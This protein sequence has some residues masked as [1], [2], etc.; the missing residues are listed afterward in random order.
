[1][2]DLKAKKSADNYT[3][4]VKMIIAWH[5]VGIATL[6]STSYFEKVRNSSENAKRNAIISAA[7]KKFQGFLQVRGHV[8]EPFE[9][10]AGPE[11]VRFQPFNHVPRSVVTPDTKGQQKLKPVATSRPPRKA[12]PAPA[13]AAPTDAT[14]AEGVPMQQEGAAENEQ[15]GQALWTKKRGG[16]GKAAAGT[17]GITKKAKGR[18]RGGRGRQSHCSVASLFRNAQPAAP[19][20]FV[21]D[22]SS[23]EFKQTFARATAAAAAKVKAEAPAPVAPVQ[24]PAPVVTQA[25]PAPTPR[26]PAAQPRV[27]ATPARVPA[28]PAMPAALQRAP[29]PP[30][31][32]PQPSM[33]AA[34]KKPEVVAVPEPVAAGGQAAGQATMKK[35]GLNFS[36]GAKPTV[37]EGPVDVDTDD[38]IIFE[39]ET[40]APDPNFLKRLAPNPP[41]LTSSP[42]ERPTQAAPMD[43]TPNKPPHTEMDRTPEKHPSPSS[44]EKTLDHLPAAQRQEVERMRQAV[45]AA[46]RARDYVEARMRMHMLE[47]RCAEFGCTVPQRAVKERGSKTAAPG[48]E[49]AERPEILDDL[50]EMDPTDRLAFTR[51]ILREKFPL[52]YPSDDFIEDDSDLYPAQERSSNRGGKRP[53]R[54]NNDRTLEEQHEGDSDIEVVGEEM[55]KAKA[56][57]AA[58]AKIEDAPYED[59]NRFPRVAETFRHFLTAGGLDPGNAE[60]EV[61][62]LHELFAQ[63]EK[64]LHAMASKEYAEV[65]SSDPLHAMVIEHF[66][67]FWS[68]N[69]QANLVPA[70]ARAERGIEV[71]TRGAH[72]IPLN[73]GVRVVQ[74]AH[75]EDLVILTAPDGVTQ[76]APASQ[77]HT[78]EIMRSPDFQNER[79]RRKAMS[80][81]EQAEEIRQVTGRSVAT[82]N[83]MEDSAPDK[84]GVKAEKARVEL[85]EGLKAMM[86]GGATTESRRKV[87]GVLFRQQVACASCGRAGRDASGAEVDD[88]LVNED[89]EM[90]NAA[91]ERTRWTSYED[92]PDATEEEKA[93][94]PAVLATFYQ[95][96]YPYLTGV[97]KLMELYKKRP[98]DMATAEFQRL[99]RHD[100]ENAQCNGFLNSAILYLRKFRETGG[101]EDLVD[102]S[103]LD[104]NKLQNLF[105]PDFSRNWNKEQDSFEDLQ[106]EVPLELLMA[107][108][109][110]EWQRE[111]QEKLDEEN[112]IQEDVDA[113]GHRPQQLSIALLPNATPEEWALWPRI[114]ARY[115]AD[116]KKACD[117]VKGMKRETP[118]GMKRE[119]YAAEL[120]NAL[121]ELIEEH[122][123]SPQAMASKKYVKI[124]RTAYLRQSERERAVTKFADFWAV[125]KDEEFP[126]PKIHS[127]ATHKYKLPELHLVEQAKR[128]ASE[129]MLPEGWAIRL[130]KDGRVIR[131]TGTQ[132]QEVYTTKEAAM[133]AAEAKAK[134]LAEEAKAQQKQILARQDAR[135]MNTNTQ[136]SLVAR[137][138][139]A[140]EREDYAAASSLQAEIGAGTGK[141]VRLVCGQA[142]EVETNDADDLARP[143]RAG[144]MPVVARDV[145]NSGGHGSGK[146]GRKG[147]KPGKKALFHAAG[148]KRKGEFSKNP[149]PNEATPLK[150]RKAQSLNKV[151]QQQAVACE[152]TL[153]ANEWRILGVKSEGLPLLPLGSEELQGLRPDQACVVLAKVDEEV[154]ERKRVHIMESWGLDNSW[155]VTIRIRRSGDQITAR[156]A[157]GK[158]FFHKHELVCERQRALRQQI[159]TNAAECIKAITSFLGSAANGEEVWDFEC[160]GCSK[161]NGLYVR[162]AS[163]S[164]EPAFEQVRALTSY[165]YGG[166]GDVVRV[167]MAGKHWQFLDASAN[168]SEAVLGYSAEESLGNPFE[169][170]S[171]KTTEEEALEVRGSLLDSEQVGV[172]AAS[173]LAQPRGPPCRYCEHAGGQA[174]AREAREASRAARASTSSISRA[175]RQLQYQARLVD[176]QARRAAAP[177]TLQ[178]MVGDMLSKLVRCQNGQMPPIFQSGK[179][180]RLGTMCS[181]TDS[182]ILVARALERVL[183]GTPGLTFEHVFSAEQDACKQEFIKA[184]FP[185]CPAIFQDVCQLGRKHAYEALSRKPQPVPGDLDL[186]LAGFSC[187]DL[188]MMNSY[189]KTLAEM[190]TSGSTLCGVLAYVER[191]R[192]RIVLLENVWAIAKANSLGFRQVDLV[193]EGLKQRGYAAGYKLLNSCDYYVPQIRHRVWMWGLRID[194]ATPTDCSYEAEAAVVAAGEKASRAVE[195]R[196]CTILRELEEPCALHFDDYMLDDDHPDVRSHFKLMSSKNR[197]CV[198][199]ARG[200][201][202]RDWLQKYSGHRTS[203]DYQYERPYTAVRDA[204]FLQVL[205]DREKELLDLKCLDVLNEQGKDPRTHPMLWELSQSVERVPGTRVRPDRQ[206]YA[207]CIL[208]GMLWHSSRHRWVLGIEKLALQGVF[209]ED[210]VDTNFPQ[211]LLG[212]LAGNAFTTTVCAAN[213]LAALTCADDVNKPR[214]AAA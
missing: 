44:A 139:A 73:W 32:V 162:N 8:G 182:P 144:C 97:R 86:S 99:V 36:V 12:A 26:A 134:R 42:P 68:A 20:P 115:E 67:Q 118:Q 108:A 170:K 122:G 18:G 159:R 6:C 39:S 202:K 103:T 21:L 157:D 93:T 178:G 156:R 4:N 41:S 161:L 102:V 110:Q 167:Q 165:G 116:M 211:K 65:V 160:A 205:N 66:C 24:P 185:S 71:R 14:P 204:D 155:T 9:A 59:L 117:D 176:L 177:K 148:Q 173:L 80:E 61:K 27:P 164:E 166:S 5:R 63:D 76:Y 189:R 209:A 206:N 128:L 129:W 136:A 85:E 113:S 82:G 84:G 55:G 169:T 45:T 35:S 146:G 78:L 52:V 98:M 192:P 199:K 194:G 207:T 64:A 51:G 13:D 125:H 79:A 193:L 40:P 38:D 58:L 25:A 180:L 43:E 15:G 112:Y 201:T 1:M 53:R 153:R 158:V 60:N 33:L 190:G 109:T 163:C 34:A 75:K 48:E 191:Y 143:S 145:Q 10:K 195:S 91:V 92:V 126:E 174:A 107:D 88:N 72:G 87:L 212:D 106:I 23:E 62:A 17:A 147:V 77:L 135:I 19:T 124:V 56:M 203:N 130:G 150:V 208:P 74:R 142:V 7:L 50:D 96:G 140:V 120:V 184:N 179:K 151:Q 11:D 100:P 200:G 214:E 123:K 49:K 30:M 141:A 70:P 198:R 105:T 168:S 28:A 89:A 138:R 213:I 210:L 16:R 188:S 121:K 171:L 175:E 183:E 181:G 3:A 137:L 186:L 149:L 22:C 37:P 127:F 47:K 133:E 131:I 29:P 2:Q 46:A 69:L 132:K 119:A 95:R 197:V 101:F 54:E 196:Y 111:L 81:W 154:R 31:A 57:K 187:K 172:R 94:Y 90:A 152:L 83:N 104:P 114:L